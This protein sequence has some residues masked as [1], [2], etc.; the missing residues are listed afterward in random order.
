MYYGAD[1]ELE[2]K[3]G[4]NGKLGW[5]FDLMRVV[6]TLVQAQTKY[7][8]KKIWQLL[9]SSMNRFWHILSK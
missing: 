9:M 6:A 2:A 1:E 8:T 3:F 7:S 4:K 5:G